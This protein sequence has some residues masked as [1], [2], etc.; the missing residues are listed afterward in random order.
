MCPK[1][2]SFH[3]WLKMSLLTILGLSDPEDHEEAG[4]GLYVVFSNFVQ[5]TVAQGGSKT[6][7]LNKT[8]SEISDLGLAWQQCFA[9]QT[10]YML[11]SF[12]LSFFLVYCLLLLVVVVVVLFWFF[13][14][15]QF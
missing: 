3:D 8:G 6:T 5:R 15:K 1:H 4:C 13:Y 2:F 11:H 12:P 9:K 7:S 14:P 10:F